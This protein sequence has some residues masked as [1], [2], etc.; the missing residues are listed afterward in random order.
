MLMIGGKG[1]FEEKTIE[2]KSI[3]EGKVVTL[4]VDKVQVHNGGQSSREIV[5]HPGGC[6]IGA[7]KDDKVI[8]VRQFRKAIE[9]N[10]LELPAGKLDPGEDPLECAVRELQEETGYI[11]RNVKSLGS[12]YP[13]PGYSNEIIHLFYS[14]DLEPG[15]AHPDEH[16]SIDIEKYSIDEVL[17]KV[18][19]G[20]IRDGKTVAGIL[21]SF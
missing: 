18:R 10:I 16:E 6:A 17:D 5:V 21:M 19:K 8:L 12:I 2:S 15:E 11:A 1:M 14:D 4:K 9:Q 7:V 3:Y 13:T 20:E